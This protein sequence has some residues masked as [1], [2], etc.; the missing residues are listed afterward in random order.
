MVNTG[1]AFKL[2]LKASYFEIYFSHV[3]TEHCIYL[4]CVV[5]VLSVTSHT[6]GYCS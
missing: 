6:S 5:I 3:V 4:L 1:H 2:K